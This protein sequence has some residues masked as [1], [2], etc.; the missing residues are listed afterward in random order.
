MQSHCIRFSPA[1]VPFSSIH[2]N[3]GYV[4]DFYEYSE[5]DTPDADRDDDDTYAKV[6]SVKKA[7][8]GAEKQGIENLPLEILLIEK[9]AVENQGQKKKIKLVLQYLRKL[10]KKRYMSAFNSDSEETE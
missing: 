10:K 1:D 7:P 6:S 8:Q 5:K 2:L 4:Y 9:Q 3:S